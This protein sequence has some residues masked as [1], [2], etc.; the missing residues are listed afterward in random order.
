MFL[1]S[2]LL[3]Y[4]FCASGF[5]LAKGAL[6][7]GTPFFFVAFRLIVA[8]LGIL[9]FFFFKK[10]KRP[11]LSQRARWDL[12]Q[13]SILSTYFA[14][15]CDLWSLQFFSSAESA[16]I[17][18]FTPFI[19]AILSWYFFRER[20]TPRKI[21][22]MLFGFFAAILLI[23]TFPHFGF[24]VLFSMPFG[25]L[26][27]A[28]FF[29][30]YGWILM[31]RLV[32]E[33]NLPVL[34]VNGISMLIAGFLALFTSLVLEWQFWK[35]LPVFNVRSFLLV[36][37]TALILVNICFTNLYSYLLKR[38]TATLLSCAGLICPFIVAALG[39]LF[40]DESLSLFFFVALGIFSLGLYLFY[41]EELLQGYYKIN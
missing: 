28:V 4:A 17:F 25:A 32:Q 20:I 2:V 6:A 33:E 21:L 9:A 19:T 30:S 38:Y 26:T 14:F 37:F 27:L 35:P 8:G 15:I 29:G 10:N 41:S 5:T 34:W 22:G 7:F 24:S 23:G 12:F 31:R 40:L 39:Y 18:N 36:T 16:F 3:L 11:Q 1:V 13:L